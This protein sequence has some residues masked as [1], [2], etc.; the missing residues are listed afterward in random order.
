MK[1]NQADPPRAAHAFQ[2]RALISVMLTLSFLLLVVSGVGLWVAPPGRIANW[3]DW[4]IFGLRKSEW[5]DLHMWFGFAFVVASVFHLVLNWRPLLSYFKGKLNRQFTLRREWL[6]AGI[7]CTAIFAGT[8]LAIPPFSTLLAFTEGIRQSWEKKSERPPIPHAELLTLSELAKQADINLTNALAR[9]A[10]H[11]IKD[12][13]PEIR[14]AELAKRNQMPAQRLYEIITAAQNGQGPSGSGGG[15]GGG[16]GGGFGRLTL[17][18]F[19]EQEGIELQA[20]QAR[21]EAKGI[22]VSAGQTLRE[23]AAGSGYQSPQ[24]I[25][26]VIRG[27]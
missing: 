18:A 16:A 9:L 24:E 25:L 4:T 22:K 14:M 5:A 19:C 8:R 17:M 13:S 26:K 3:T 27:K 15:S 11:G 6:A 21:L 7:L 12:A 20:A 2:W 10:E 23:I 1:V